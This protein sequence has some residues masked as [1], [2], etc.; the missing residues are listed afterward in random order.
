MM[1]RTA[2][3]LVAALVLIAMVAAVPSASTAQTP[4]VTP[5]KDKDTPLPRFDMY[6]ELCDECRAKL[7]KRMKDPNARPMLAPQ[8]QKRMRSDGRKAH[9]HLERKAGKNKIHRRAE[10]RRK[11]R[12]N[13]HREMRGL[14]LSDAQREQL[15]EMRHE[16]QKLMVDLQ[17]ALKKERLELQHALRSQDVSEEKLRSHVDRVSQRRADIEF[18]KLK[19]RLDRREVLTEEQRKKAK[20]SKRRR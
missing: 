20:R 17:A 13:A 9:R 11:A 1:K 10:M 3:A 19:S 14:G 6:D 15:R 18:E 4:Q 16:Q 5:P 12:R 7:K 2:G 8:K